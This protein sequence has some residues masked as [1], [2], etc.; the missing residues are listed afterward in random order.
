MKPTDKKLNE[1]IA[2][3]KDGKIS[4]GQLAETLGTN[5]H[6]ALRLLDELNI[7]FADYDLNE[8]LETIDELFPRPEW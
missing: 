8:D 6:E 1:L 5:K 7:P 2:A 4:L 3:F